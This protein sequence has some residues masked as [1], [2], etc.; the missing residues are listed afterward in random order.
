L[1]YLEQKR[2]EAQ[3]QY[4]EEQKYIQQNKEYLEGLLKKEQEMMASEVPGTLW[5]AI[6]QLS[7][8]PPKKKDPTQADKEVPGQGDKT[9]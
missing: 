8:E 5:E 4:Q 9:A 1:T 7:G 6:G 2:L 3:Q